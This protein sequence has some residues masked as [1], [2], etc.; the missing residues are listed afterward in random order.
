MVYSRYYLVVICLVSVV[1]FSLSFAEIPVVIPLGAA[2]QNNPFSLSPSTL[3]VQVN[4]TVT[5]KNQDTAVHTVTTGKS[6]L[7]FDGRIDSGI[8]QPGGT[9]SY[10]FT[11]TGLYQYY[12]L[13]HPWMTGF[14]NVGTSTPDM[15]IGILVSTDKSVYSKGD[16]IHV[17]GQVSQFIANKQ[18]TVWATDSKGT[19]ISVV[20]TE[21][22]TGRNFG[23]DIP[24]T[25]TQWIPGNNYTIYAQ[26]GPA[27][28]VATA[29]VQYEPE[30]SNN[31]VKNTVSD[32]IPSKD[33]Y[34]SSYKKT[35]PDSNGYVTVQT[36]RHVYTADSPVIVSGAIWDGVFVKVGGGAYLATVPIS[37]T[38]G[39][40]MAEL[41]DIT[42]T[43]LNGNIVSS[44]QVQVSS[45]GSYV[46][47]MKIPTDSDGL[48]H[49]QAQLKTKDGLVQ[50][51]GGDVMSKLGSS[52]NFL[53]AKPD[54]FSVPTNLGKYDVDISSNS[55]VTG[56]TADLAQKK[57]SFNVQ[58]ESGTHGTTDVVVPKTVLG[59]QIQVLIDGIVQPYGSDD[60]IVTSDTA[61]ETGFEINYHHS[62]HTID[63]VGSS[64]AEPLVYT[65]AVPEFGLAPVILTLSVVGIIVV[66]Y[67]TRL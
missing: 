56:F 65:Q 63:L 37:D 50:T 57:I 14:V 66:S 27:S 11:K 29:L 48:Y 43:D 15:P 61:S 19:G 64:A 13:F 30:L 54:T 17:S 53:V 45:D 44:K 3:E 39:N 60:V 21:T 18:V 51:L 34:M 6:G 26:Y 52:T 24:V 9:F 28:S 23:V 25:A 7:G 33:E 62:V 46:T 12:C 59:G 5:W 10:T 32:V 67:R 20:H 16:V 42:I 55:T 47:Q 38:T 31:T 49:V 35:I 1:T 36:G 8:I 58:G 41:V 2:N 40:T 22:R 4:D